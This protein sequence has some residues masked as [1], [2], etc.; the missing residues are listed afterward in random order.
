MLIFPY[1]FIAFAKNANSKIMVFKGFSLVEK[2]SS[3]SICIN[4]L[5]YVLFSLEASGTVF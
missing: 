3:D 1:F 5:I 2:H 4:G